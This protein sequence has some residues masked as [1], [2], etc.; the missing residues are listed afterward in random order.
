MEFKT[1]GILSLVVILWSTDT[2]SLCIFWKQSGGAALRKKARDFNSSSKTVCLSEGFAGLDAPEPQHTA[3]MSG[4]VSILQQFANG[5][6][7][8][9]EE[10]RAKAAKDLQHYV[11]ME[12]REVSAANGIIYPCV[13]CECGPW[14]G[15][16]GNGDFWNL[17]AG[18]REEMGHS[19]ELI[20]SPWNVG[21]VSE[22]M[23]QRDSQ[24]SE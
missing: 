8:R 13:S 11:T 14:A 23:A 22:L 6:K 2:A 15:C 17:E 1:Q 10:T 21:N 9:S 24:V 20:F 18:I 5:L 12:L 7:S 4:T 19:R 16:L 3:T